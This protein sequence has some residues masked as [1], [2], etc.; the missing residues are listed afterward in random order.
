LVRCVKP[1]RQI[2][3]T[4]TAAPVHG[5][6]PSVNEQE[7]LD[8][9]SKQTQ[10][11]VHAIRTPD[12]PNIRSSLEAASSGF[13]VEWKLPPGLAASQVMDKARQRE[14]EI[15]DDIGWRCVHLQE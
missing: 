6:H 7:Q 2:N 5:A 1:N 14:K 8:N 9:T 4:R 3:W 10:S 12:S 15:R 11:T 13:V